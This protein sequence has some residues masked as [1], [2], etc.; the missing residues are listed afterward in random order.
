MPAFNMCRRNRILPQCRQYSSWRH[1]CRADGLDD[2]PSKLAL[3]KVHHTFNLRDG[4]DG[5][6]ERERR[7]RQGD[8]DRELRESCGRP[9]KASWSKR[10]RMLAHEL[11]CLAMKNKGNGEIGSSHLLEAISRHRFRVGRQPIPVSSL[12]VSH[13]SCKEPFVRPGLI[14]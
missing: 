5:A 14:M 9:G 10:C 8:G 7:Y 11:S 1:V 3:A 13:Y 6:I 2:G 4:H 12:K